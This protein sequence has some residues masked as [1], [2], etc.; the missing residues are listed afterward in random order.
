[1]KFID[2]TTKNRFVYGAELFYLCSLD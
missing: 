1:M 2:Q